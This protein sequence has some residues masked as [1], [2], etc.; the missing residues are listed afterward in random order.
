M[1]YKYLYKYGTD[2]QIKAFEQARVRAMESA[3]LLQ[4]PSIYSPSPDF[5]G[6]I[7]AGSFRSGILRTFEAQLYKTNR[8]DSMRGVVN[9]VAQSG[10]SGWH[11][12]GGQM[13]KEL[14]IPVMRL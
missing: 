8:E 5:Q 10:R 3:R 9:N 12:W 14:S 7:F 1:N 11:G 2:E 13:A 4:E 6:F